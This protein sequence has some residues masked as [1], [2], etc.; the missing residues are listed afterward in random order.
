[1]A[2]TDRARAKR[3]AML[4]AV[5]AF[6]SLAQAGILAL[7]THEAGRGTSEALGQILD[8]AVTDDSVRIDHDRLNAH[9]AA[10]DPALAVVS[11]AD[12]GAWLQEHWIGPRVRFLGVSKTLMSI[13]LGLA[14]LVLACWI[15][16]SKSNGDVQQVGTIR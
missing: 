3:M 10:I 7:D 9:L 11:G 1:M 12:S 13:C 5:F 8:D 6:M 15:W 4:A 2:S 14:F 16:P